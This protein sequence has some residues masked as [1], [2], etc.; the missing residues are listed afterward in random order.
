MPSWGFTAHKHGTAADVDLTTVFKLAIRP[1][2]AIGLKM[3][4]ALASKKRLFLGEE[5]ARLA[6]SRIDLRFQGYIDDT[7]IRYLLCRNPNSDVCDE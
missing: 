2:R 1:L 3:D 7:C 6:D 5:I 4:V